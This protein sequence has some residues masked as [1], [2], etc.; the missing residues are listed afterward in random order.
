MSVLSMM[1]HL[2]DYVGQMGFKYSDITATK[3][4]C[5]I[6]WSLN[7][8]QKQV[9]ISKNVSCIKYMK[10]IVKFCKYIKQNIFWVTCVFYQSC[11]SPSL[12]WTNRILFIETRRIYIRY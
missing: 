8:S 1:L 10:Y 12:A 11:I 3:M 6:Q 9:T 2:L 5:T 4:I 7:I